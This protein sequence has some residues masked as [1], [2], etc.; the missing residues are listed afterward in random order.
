MDSM[1]RPLRRRG[2]QG[3]AW[4]FPGEG[5][6]FRMHM[7]TKS[8]EKENGEPKPHEHELL[9]EFPA[10]AIC[11]NDITSSCL[12]VCGLCAADAGVYAPLAVSLVICTLYLFRKIY[13][14]VCSALPMNGGTFSVLL[15]TTTKKIAAA[16]SCMG[17]LSYVATGVVSASEAVNYLAE[18]WSEC[19]VKTLTV[20]L[21]AVFAFLNLVGISESAGAAMVIFVLHTTTLLLLAITAL[22]YIFMHGAH[23]I[24]ESYHSEYQPK[25]SEAIFYGFGAAMLG[26]SG[27]ETSAQFIE[28]QAPGVFTKTLRNMWLA[29]SIINPILTL[30]AL[31]IVPLG[32]I[33]E[34]YSLTLLARM[35]E[36]SGGQWLKN[37][38][39]ADA[40]LVLSGAVL[41]SYVGAVGLVRRLALDSCLP[42]FLLIKNHVRG[43]NHYIILGF[44]GVCTSMFIILEGDASTLSKVYSVSFLGLMILFGVGNLLLKVKRSALRR[45]DRAPIWSVLLGMSLVAA[46][47]V[48]TVV[49]RP[50]VL[51]VFL[52]YYFLA[53]FLVGIMFFRLQVLKQVYRFLN[54]FECFD[55]CLQALEEYLKHMTSRPLIF[56][57]KG[58]SAGV[59]NKAV[60]YIMENEETQ[61]IK[62]VHFEDPNETKEISHN[63]EKTIRFLDRVYPKFKIDLVVVESSFSPEGVEELSRKLDI[64]QN[65]MFMACPSSE[66][67]ETVASLGGVRIITH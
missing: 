7:E 53:A 28:E 10:T 23:P 54:Q 26:V 15:H 63:I 36:V 29:V 43:T 66:F 34:E 22:V 61:F 24:V 44:F 27:F 3:Y 67:R 17:I 19:P 50:D 30:Q 5:D 38:V 48:S 45:D 55:S 52:L 42:E 58:D 33:Q 1:S 37:I 14:E 39:C 13:V 51:L 62:F 16:S 21:L 41:T 46:G 32:E 49:K 18:I 35:G 47:L 64:P 56:L 59:M 11:G 6:V 65:C 2:S 57:V 8:D 31:C 4:E 60:I 12:Y 9:S 25:I 40:F 20:C